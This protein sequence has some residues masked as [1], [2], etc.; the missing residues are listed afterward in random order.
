MNDSPPSLA[1]VWWM[2]ARPKTLFAAF[3]PVAMGAAMVQAEQ[4]VEGLILLWTLLA[5]MGVQV[6]TNFCNDVFDHRQGADTEQR[7][8]P[9]RG[10][11]SGR[12][13]VPALSLATALAFAVPLLC[14]IPLAARAGNWIWGLGIISVACGVAYTAG[15]RSLAYTGLADIFVIIFFGPVALAGTYVLQIPGSWPPPEVWIAGLAPGCIATALLSVNNLRDVDEDRVNNKRTLAVRFGS[16]FA[17]S[18]Y[19]VCIAIALL[20]PLPAALLAGRG[21]GSLLVWL[22]L[23]LYVPLLKQ[24]RIAS[25]GKELNPMLGKTGL[26]L[27][28]FS[29]LFSLGWQW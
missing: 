15:R 21:W 13:S 10:L 25:S 7:Q 4:P 18:E 5:A 27:L 12:I 16:S 2:T 29:L 28:L 22:L 24:I 9:R 6:G 17:R 11:Q 8:G 26:S 14:C 19:R 1:A 3:A 23:P 20:C